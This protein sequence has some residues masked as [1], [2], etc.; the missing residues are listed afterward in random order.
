MYLSSSQTYWRINF[1]LFKIDFTVWEIL[2]LNIFKT[3]FKP[4]IIIIIHSLVIIILIVC[5]NHFA[6]F[7]FC[8]SVN[9]FSGRRSGPIAKC[10]IVK[11]LVKWTETV[12][13]SE[14]FLKFWLFFVLYTKNKKIFEHFAAKNVKFLGLWSRFRVKGALQSNTAKKLGFWFLSSFCLKLFSTLRSFFNYARKT[15]NIVKSSIPYRT[16]ISF[17][18]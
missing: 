12:R 7:F 14:R 4:T 11:K 13:Y 18:T 2:L 3:H 1:L 5:L 16:T 9:I 8:F 17:H 10:R 15:T 6:N